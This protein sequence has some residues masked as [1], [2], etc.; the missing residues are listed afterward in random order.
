MLSVALTLNLPQDFPPLADV[1][2]W[3][4]LAWNP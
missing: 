1:I 4:Q 2:A 3:D